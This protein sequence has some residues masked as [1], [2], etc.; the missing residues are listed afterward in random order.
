MTEQNYFSMKTL[1]IM[2][3]YKITAFI[4]PDLKRKVKLT[5]NNGLLATVY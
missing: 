1:L 3:Y 2:I 5:K 4:N